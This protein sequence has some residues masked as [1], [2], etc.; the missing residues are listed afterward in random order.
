MNGVVKEYSKSVKKEYADIYDYELRI[1]REG[2][3]QH[4]TV[5]R[6]R[7]ECLYEQ[8][9]G[10]LTELQEDPLYSEIAEGILNH[11][12]ASVR[13]LREL[14]EQLEEELDILSCH[15]SSIELMRS[16]GVLG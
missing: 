2:V 7:I 11:L 1:E 6:S 14:E 13:E 16:T 9:E 12:T 15:A 5:V 4:I 3:M 8:I 10:I